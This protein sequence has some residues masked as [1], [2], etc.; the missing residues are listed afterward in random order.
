MDATEPSFTRRSCALHFAART[1]AH[2]ML[3]CI[4]TGL[5]FLIAEAY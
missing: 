5:L 3:F 4:A 2:F 1:L